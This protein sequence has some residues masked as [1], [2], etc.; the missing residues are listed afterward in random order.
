MLIDDIGGRWR[1][2][3]RTL[4]ASVPSEL[5]HS[6]PPTRCALIELDVQGKRRPHPFVVIALFGGTFKEPLWDIA[7]FHFQGSQSNAG[8][9]LWKPMVL[10]DE[11]GD[12]GW[13]GREKTSRMEDS[14]NRVTSAE[15]FRLCKLPGW[16]WARERDRVLQVG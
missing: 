12:E 14:L 16:T 4:A 3:Q 10:F 11:H 8:P 2:L 6:S 13:I 9:L 1:H 5:A 15:W 7:S